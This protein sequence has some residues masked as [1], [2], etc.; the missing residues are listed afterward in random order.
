MPQLIGSSVGAKGLST[1]S[2]SVW[3]P[4]SVMTLAL[5]IEQRRRAGSPPG[6]QMCTASI[7]HK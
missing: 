4:T 3:S 1:L 5:K 6:C 2:S 7:S